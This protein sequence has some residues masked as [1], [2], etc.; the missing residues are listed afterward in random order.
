[1]DV[2]KTFSVGADYIFVSF[3]MKTNN[4]YDNEAAKAIELMKEG[5]VA[6]LLINIQITSYVITYRPIHFM[7]PQQHPAF[8]YF[9]Q[10]VE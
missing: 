10:M 6:R 7:P 8:K 3:I 2:K 1:M 4:T 5:R 9:F